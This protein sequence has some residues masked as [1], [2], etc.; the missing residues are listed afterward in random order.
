MG[1]SSSSAPG[2]SFRT[3]LPPPT[4]IPSAVAHSACTFLGCLGA[5]SPSWPPR[6]FP[7]WDIAEPLC[8]LLH[9]CSCAHA[10]FLPLLDAPTLPSVPVLGAPVCGSAAGPCCP[11]CLAL[12]AQVLSRRCRRRLPPARFGPSRVGASARSSSPGSAAFRTR[13]LT[14]FSCPPCPIP[15]PCQPPPKSEHLPPRG[16]SSAALWTKPPAPCCCVSAVLPLVSAAASVCSGVRN[17]SALGNARS[18]VGFST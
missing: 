17:A 8:A 2:S 7:P 1:G 15:A 13:F 16:C 3:V 11:V 4:R 5:S 9:G 6:V 14:R 10:V 18:V 12:Q